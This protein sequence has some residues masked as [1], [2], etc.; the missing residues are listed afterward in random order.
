MPAMTIV[1]ITSMSVK[2]PS[3]DDLGGRM[4]PKVLRMP[5][6]SALSTVT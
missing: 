1:T 4:H 3:R 2:P 5:Q 6:I